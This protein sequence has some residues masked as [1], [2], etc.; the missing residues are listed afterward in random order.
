MLQ[1]CN[2]AMLDEIKR[3]EET[4]RETSVQIKVRECL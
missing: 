2:I 3:L 4:N 1:V